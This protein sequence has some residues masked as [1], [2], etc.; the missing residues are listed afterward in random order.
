MDRGYSIA[1]KNNQVITSVYDVKTNDDIQIQVRDGLIHAAVTS[2]E[3][4][5]GKN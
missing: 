1:T 3:N 5:H 4:E 2:K